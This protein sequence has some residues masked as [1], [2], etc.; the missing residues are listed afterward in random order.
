[1]R[2][3]PPQTPSGWYVVAF[4]DEV[5]PIGLYR[6]YVKQFYPPEALSLVERS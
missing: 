4:S 5:K 1:M 3:P 6:R 2:N